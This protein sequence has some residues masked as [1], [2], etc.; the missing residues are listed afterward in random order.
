MEGESENFSG[1]IV[2]A[3][4]SVLWFVFQTTQFNSQ[5][6]GGKAASCGGFGGSANANSCSGSFWKESGATV[7]VPAH[8][9]ATL[10]H[11]VFF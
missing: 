9:S 6:T 8:N 7:Q 11:P 3:G 10:S 1:A 4:F 2:L 5:N